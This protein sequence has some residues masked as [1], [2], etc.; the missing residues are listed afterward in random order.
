MPCTA[1]W[2]ALSAPPPLA[3]GEVHLW[4]IRVP[5]GDNVP[6]R[7]L[8]ILTAEEKAAAARKRLPPDRQ[9][10]LTSRACLRLLLSGYLGAPPGALVFVASAHGKP[11]LAAPSPTPPLEF[12]VSHSGEWVILGFARG[13]TLG[14]DVECHRELEFNQLVT[15]FFSPLERA[16]W[17]A[18]PRGAQPGAFF[19][20]WTRKE[21]YLKA[22][23]LGLSK[24][25]D[26]FAVAFEPCATPALIWCSS[27]PAAP[28]HW[29]LAAPDL[30]PGY[31]CAVATP[32]SATR[33][34]TFT[35]QPTTAPASALQ[36]KFSPKPT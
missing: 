6:P 26:S 29:I 36:A 23:G 19:A 27:D 25:I 17:A 1:D 20:A 15:A 35:L 24:P 22:L 13:M 31:S 12:N 10:T 2:T 14:V 7:W 4:R 34:H 16:A 30:T 3:G 5:D 8:E 11:R 32:A 21:A 9:R 18:L 33:L 28:Q